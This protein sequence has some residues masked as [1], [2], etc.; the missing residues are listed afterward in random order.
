MDAAVGVGEGLVD[1]VGGEG[2]D[3]GGEAGEGVGDLVDGGLRAAAG[4]V[5]P[6]LLGVARLEFDGVGVEAVLEY[7]EVEG[8]EFGVEELVEQVVDAVELEVLV[9][10]LA[11]LGG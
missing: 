10:R 11:N 7:V 4:E 9:R 1:L 3:G 8:A 6:L 5:E 2:E